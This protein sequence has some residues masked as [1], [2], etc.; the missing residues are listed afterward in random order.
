MTLLE[1]F[2]RRLEENKGNLTKSAVDLV[3][4]CASTGP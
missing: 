1:R 3:K 4:E 2:E